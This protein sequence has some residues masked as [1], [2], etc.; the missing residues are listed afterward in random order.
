MTTIGFRPA[1]YM[2]SENAGQITFMFGVLDGTLGFAVVIEFLTTNGTAFEGI[3]MDDIQIT[4]CMR[5]ILF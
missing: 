3:Y 1:N 5:K 2:A 4:F